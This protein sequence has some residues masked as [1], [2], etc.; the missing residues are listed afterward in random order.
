MKKRLRKKF[1][2]GEFQSFGFAVLGSTSKL[3]TS[4]EE[5]LFLDGFICFAEAHGL[6]IGGGIA[7]RS[8]DYYVTKAGRYQT[9]TDL[10][11]QLV[12][13]LLKTRPEV[14]SVTV[15][16]LTDAWNGKY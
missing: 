6:A 11:R 5:D 14:Q 15:G 10:D 8:L 13:S 3:L 2:L 1:H 7:H 16:A 12:E 4:A 9:C